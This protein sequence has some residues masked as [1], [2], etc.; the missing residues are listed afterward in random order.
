MMR[1]IALPI[2]VGMMTTTLLTLIAIPVTYYVYQSRKP[3]ES[4]Y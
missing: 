4:D 3:K 2:V 1:R